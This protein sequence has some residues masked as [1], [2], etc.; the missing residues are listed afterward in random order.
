MT[1][2]ELGQ[3]A[4]SKDTH[5]HSVCQQQAW[6]DMPAALGSSPA[7]CAHVWAEQGSVSVMAS[8]CPA[9]QGKQERVGPA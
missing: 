6:R 7:A 4:S 8:G 2:E 9:A 3:L 5:R 1:V